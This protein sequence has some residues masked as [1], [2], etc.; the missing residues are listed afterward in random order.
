MLEGQFSGTGGVH[1]VCPVA[2]NAGNR[3]AIV[4][5]HDAIYLTVLFEFVYVRRL[6]AKGGPMR[7]ATMPAGI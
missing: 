7:F 3:Y 2:N 1:Y 6:I 4:F 5:H